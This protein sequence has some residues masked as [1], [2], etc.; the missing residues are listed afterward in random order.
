MTSMR[1]AQSVVEKVIQRL[2][3]TSGCTFLPAPRYFS[4]CLEFPEIEDYL[5]ASDYSI[6]VAYPDNSA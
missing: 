4:A 6:C 3:L 5:I 2:W 1:F